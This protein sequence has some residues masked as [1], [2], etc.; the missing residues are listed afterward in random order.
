MKKTKIITVVLM[1]AVFMFCMTGCE[2]TSGSKS[3]KINSAK[4]Q[5]TLTNVNF[6]DFFNYK[7]VSGYSGTSY[8]PSNGSTS[9]AITFVDKN[10]TTR[11]ACVNTPLVNKPASV[12]VYI[13]SSKTKFDTYDC[14]Y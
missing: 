14:K 3:I 11:T 7:L 1:I 10:G 6:Y 9:T 13:N 2:G 4:S 12:K 5:M 8:V